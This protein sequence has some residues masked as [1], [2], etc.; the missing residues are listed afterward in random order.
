MDRPAGSM[1][2]EKATGDKF[3]NEFIFAKEGA[4]GAGIA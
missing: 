1:S 2:P 4:D 3:G